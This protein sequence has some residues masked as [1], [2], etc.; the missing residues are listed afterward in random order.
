LNNGYRTMEEA[1]AMKRF[2]V[3]AIFALTLSVGSLPSAAFAAARSG[4]QVVDLEH[5]HEEPDGSITYFTLKG[6]TNS[7]LTPEGNTIYTG[8]VRTT[9]T[10]YDG[11]GNRVL[12]SEGTQ[13]QAR[14]TKDPSTGNSE[15]LHVWSDRLASTITYPDGRVCTFILAIQYANGQFQIWTDEVVCT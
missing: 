5:S 2:I 9:A 6:E 3:F 11:A 12:T 4:A 14:L 10:M 13:H 15:N 7:T 8:N 1:H